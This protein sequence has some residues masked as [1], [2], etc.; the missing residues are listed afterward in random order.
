MSRGPEVLSLPP[1]ML[2]RNGAV[3]YQP[4]GFLSSETRGSTA[5]YLDS[6]QAWQ[7]VGNN[8][9][10]DN[11]YAYNNATSARERVTLLEA[12]TKNLVLQSD[13]LATTWT[14]V[15]SPVV[16][17]AAA[18]AANR[19]FSSI[20]FASAWGTDYVKQAITFTGNA[21]KGL[22]FLFKQNG[23][24]AGTFS[25]Q[26]FDSTGSASKMT[27]T[28]TVAADGTMTAAASTGTLQSFL[29]EANGVYR[30]Q[31][32]ATSVTAA[33]TNEIRIGT[34]GTCPSILV[35]GVMAVDNVIVGSLYPTTTTTL[36]R[37]ADA[38]ARSL[39]GTGLALPREST[40][41]VK[42]VELGTAL[43]NAA[44]VLQLSSVG[45]ARLLINSNG[46]HYFATISDGTTT[47]ST[48]AF[49]TGPAQNDQAE[50]LLYVGPD[51]KITLEQSVN[52][53]ASTVS[54]ATAALTLPAAWGDKN[55]ELGQ[56]NGS[57]S[58][59]GFLGLQSVKAIPG[60]YTLAQMRGL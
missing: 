16:A 13:A 7:S 26:L 59:A 52:G 40:W 29:A 4:G 50:L 60:N 24:D 45:G 9:L 2:R 33:D 55:L 39:A 46:V 10:R 41:Y 18:T 5:F 14:A 35:S 1:W 36:T 22:A 20:A 23:T 15:G 30:M 12:S 42:F 58:S 53:A 47:N 34:A 56:S 21:V 6:A 51:G 32:Q 31:V 27:A 11:A 25:V 8:V 44:R 48:T 38:A 37:S 19:P 3:V 28:V 54:A 43:V 57:G 49:S 17:N